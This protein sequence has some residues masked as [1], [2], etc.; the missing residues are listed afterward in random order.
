MGAGSIGL[1]VVAMARGHGVVV[2]LV[3]RHPVQRAAG[4][5]LGATFSLHDAYDVVIVCAG[6]Q[7]ALDTAIERLR[8]GG[9][10]VAP[11][12]WFDPAQVGTALMMKEARLVPSY[13]YGHHHGEREFAEAA[14]LLADDPQIA[15]TI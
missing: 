2:D 6:T 9:T 15:E 7:S 14:Q 4:E 8:P 10:I 1:A 3:A 12:T 11:A 5:R 13:V